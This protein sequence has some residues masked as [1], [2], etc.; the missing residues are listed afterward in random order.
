[1]SRTRAERKAGFCLATGV[2]PSEYEALSGFEIDA[3]IELANHR[4][5]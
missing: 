2:Q 3:F 1:M 4:N 5:A